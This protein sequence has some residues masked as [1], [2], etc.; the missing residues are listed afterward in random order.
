MVCGA[1]G[2]SRGT[3]RIRH[4]STVSSNFDDY[5]ILTGADMPEVEVVA[6]DSEDP[7]GGIGEPGYPPLGPAVLN[8]LFDATGVRIRKLPLAG[9]LAGQ[10]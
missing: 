6:V 10:G 5:R 7:I 3:L 1:A 8:A 9:Q 2:K 4:G